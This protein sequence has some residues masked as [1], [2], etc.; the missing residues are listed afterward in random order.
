MFVNSYHNTIYTTI[1]FKEDTL[2]QSQKV[3]DTNVIII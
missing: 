2:G 1:H 3:I